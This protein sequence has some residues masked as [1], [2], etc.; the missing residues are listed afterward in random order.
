MTMEEARARFRNPEVVIYSLEV[1]EVDDDAPGHG[2]ALGA[3]SGTAGLGRLPRQRVAGE[4]KGED[5]VEELSKQV[6][7]VYWWASV[8]VV[9]LLV[10]WA[11]AYSKDWIDTGRAKLSTRWREK[12]LADAGAGTSLA[13]HSW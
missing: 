13:V 10:N 3:P 5:A 11:A 12:W 4:R 8:V 9:G 6:S 2:Q 7:S 1:R